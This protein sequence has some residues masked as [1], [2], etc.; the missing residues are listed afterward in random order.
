M[1]KISL[2][3]QKIIEIILKNGIAQSSKI[4]KELTL[5]EDI[6]SD[7]ETRILNSATA[8]YELRIKDLPQAIQKKELERLIIELSWKSSRIEGNTYTLLV[9]EKLILE[10]KEA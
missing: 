6:F 10:N 3:Q 1:R 5:S 7:D 8:E 4:H 9:T 2:K